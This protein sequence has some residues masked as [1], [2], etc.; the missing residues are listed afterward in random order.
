MTFVA[1]LVLGVVLRVGAAAPRLGA[2]LSGSDLSTDEAMYLS[3]A[4]NLR[5]HAA[6]ATASD[7]NFF[8]RVFQPI[9]T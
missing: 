3:I 7:K 6:F 4:S 2:G 1:L 5:S 9:S 8:D